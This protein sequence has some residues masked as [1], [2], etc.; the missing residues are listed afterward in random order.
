MG[1]SRATKPTREQK[2]RMTRAGYDPKDFLV[3]RDSPKELTLVR[4]GD[5]SIRKIEKDPAAG[6]ARVKCRYK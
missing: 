5:G 1:K 3:I 4:R 6:T 2:A